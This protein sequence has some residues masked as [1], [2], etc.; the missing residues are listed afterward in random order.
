EITVSFLPTPLTERVL[1]LDW[2]PA[3]ALRYLLTGGDKLHHY[4]RPDLPFTL[5]NN[6]GPTENSVVSTS[7]VVLSEEKND[8]APAIGRPIANTTGY[9]LDAQLQP[10]PV[11][12]AGELFV[13]GESLA[14]G[15][16][17]RPEL[18]AERFLPDPFASKAPD[19]KR[20]YFT[21]DR[22]RYAPD[23]QIAFLGR[24]DFQVK[25]RGF[26][27]EL[28]EIEAA[29]N[30]HGD[31]SETIVVARD[32]A[33]GDAKLVAYL[34]PKSGQLPEVSALRRSLAEKLPEYMIPSAF[35][36]MQDGFPL[37]PNGKVDRRALPAPEGIRQVTTEY[38]AP[39]TQIEQQIAK[40]WQETLRLERVGL[41]DNF[42]DL[43]GHSLVLIQVHGK[44]KAL[45]DKEISIVD[46][47][48]YT[49]VNALA[50]FLTNG[51]ATTVL[52]DSENAEKLSAGKDRLRQLQ[53][54]RQVAE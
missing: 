14:R 39:Q 22:V 27:I 30:R 36:L 49:T 34:V 33:P 10:L 8:A 7:G 12:V 26:R 18:T 51:E 17:H 38:I 3:M 21:G 42:F 35:V 11:G 44:L 4:P 48:K 1:P 13:G 23:G 40:V 15:Y 41:H 24:S 2:P 20:L 53:R 6:Y 5:V 19:G 47:F 32:E 29:I 43:G 52:K 25:I 46:L 16:L 31:V 28:G 37:T 9:I 45:F 54:R 50:E